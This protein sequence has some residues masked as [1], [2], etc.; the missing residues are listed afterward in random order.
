MK[1]I[2]IILF[3]IVTQ[4][5][6][7]NSLEFNKLQVEC[8]NKWVA[9]PINKDKTYSYGYIYFDNTAGLTLNFEGYFKKD[10]NKNFYIVKDTVKNKPAFLKVRLQPNK[11]LVAELP[12]S[13]I[14]NLGLEKV[15]EWLKIYREGENT[16]TALYNKGYCY[17]AWGFYD[18]AIENLLKAYQSDKNYKGLRTE[19]AFSYNA[20]KKY[21]EAVK[22]LLEELKVAPD[23]QYTYK[24]LAFAYNNLKKFDEVLKVY[25]KMVKINKNHDYILETAHNI[26]YEYFLLKDKDNFNFWKSEANKW[27]SPNDRYISNINLMDKELNK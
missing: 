12:D 16:T 22:I 4:A 24:E 5:N 25:K 11:T 3:A 17:N 7:Q 18:K 9:Y 26:A 14:S 10:D 23:N 1:K 15:P 19:L 2:A 21:D 6:A 8:I 27:G 13:I 20:L